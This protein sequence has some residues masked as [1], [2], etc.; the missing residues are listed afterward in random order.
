[1]DALTFSAK[2]ARPVTQPVE[3]ESLDALPGSHTV[4]LRQ[5]AT[6][7]TVGYNFYGQLWL[8]AC[9]PRLGLGTPDASG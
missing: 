7:W 3:I 6:V 5:N 1:M 8:A 2:P 4:A 9:D